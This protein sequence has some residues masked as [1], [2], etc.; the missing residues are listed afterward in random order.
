MKLDNTRVKE[1]MDKYCGKQK[2][3]LSSNMNITRVKNTVLD[4]RQSTVVIRTTWC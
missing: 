1:K 4:T 3:L 2:Q